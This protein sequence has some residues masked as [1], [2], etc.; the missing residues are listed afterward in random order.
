VYGGLVFLFG[1]ID[2]SEEVSYNDL[3]VLNTLSWEWKY[4]GEA[5]SEIISRNS[6]SLEVL[7]SRFI[8]D[9]SFEATKSI[10]QI[11]EK[12]YLVLY[13]G[14]SPEEGPLGDTYY[15]EINNNWTEIA[16]NTTDF[17]VTWHHLEDK[18]TVNP[19]TI[20]IKSTISHPGKREMQ[21]SCVVNGSSM[22]ITGGR[23]ETGAVLDDVW[24]LS[25]N[26]RSDINSNE[27]TLPRDDDAKRN[28][29]GIVSDGSSEQVDAVCVAAKEAPVTQQI[30][31]INKASS[32]SRQDGRFID[33]I[34]ADPGVQSSR[35][36]CTL[37][38]CF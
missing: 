13:G 29:L 11:G 31:V 7:C 32:A 2:F 9:S 10:E 27:S 37:F 33:V 5:G 15:A 28:L 18:F 26:E 24:M 30:A 20:G 36:N 8:G 25:I 6:H 22:I 17:F 16:A 12:V 4:V 1:G 35:V 21:S 3:Y 23:N 38:V 34:N 14:A 19:D